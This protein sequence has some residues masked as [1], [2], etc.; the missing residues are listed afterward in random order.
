MF[1]YTDSSKKIKWHGTALGKD[2]RLRFVSFVAERFWWLA[3]AMHRGL[4]QL[5]TADVNPVTLSDVDVDGEYYES[6]EFTVSEADGAMAR[7]IAIAVVELLESLQYR[8]LNAVVP[9]RGSEHDLVAEKR[10]LPMQSSVEVVCRTIQKPSILCDTVRKQLRQK[11]L[12]LWCSKAFSERL[13]VLVE[14]APGRLE[15]GWR[16]LRCEAYNASKQWKTLCGWQGGVAGQVCSRAPPQAAEV[17]RKR[18]AT[19]SEPVKKR[20]IANT[21]AGRGNKFLYIA[22]TKYSTLPWYLGHQAVKSELQIALACCSSRR[23]EFR[24]GCWNTMDRHWGQEL[25]DP[26]VVDNFRNKRWL[27]TLCEK[28]KPERAGLQVKLLSDGRQ[29]STSKYLWCL[30]EL[31]KC[32]ALNK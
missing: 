23:V 26:S 30:P 24:A 25:L 32:Q 12:K 3:F 13:T 4:N 27:S 17:K 5:T 1:D 28:S 2:H 16:I 11:A 29:P 6:T 7:R 22:G 20:T 9:F 21:D 18:S 10:G 31:E 14:F 19:P 8:V 15:D